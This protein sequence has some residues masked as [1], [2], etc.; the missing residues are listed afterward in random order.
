LK[1]LGRAART[2]GRVGRE[3]RMPVTPLQQPAHARVFQY[4]KGTI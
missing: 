2:L 4:G 3:L 1:F